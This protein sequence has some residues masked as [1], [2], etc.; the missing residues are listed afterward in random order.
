MTPPHLLVA[1][2]DLHTASV[3]GI[4]PPKV[5]LDNG[6]YY[7]ANQFQ[8]Y[9]W[10]IWRDM[11]KAIK[12]K[13]RVLGVPVTTIIMGDS[14]D[15]NKYSKN[16]VFAHNPNSMLRA[17]DELLKPVLK[18]SERVYVLRGTPAHEGE[19][20]WLAE[21]LA[22]RIKAV[23]RGKHNYSWW[24]LPIEVSGVL[25]DIK[26]HPESGDMRWWTAGGGMIRSAA[27]V[28]FD[29]IE[30]KDM[31]PQV[32]LR[33]HRHQWRDSGTNMPT[34]AFT[35]PAWQ[36][37]TD[38]IHRIGAGGSKVPKFGCAWFYCDSG[39]YEWGRF[40]YQPDRPEAEVI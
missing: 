10:D 15:K 30:T 13:T 19:E 26:H 17:A 28:I 16:G 38:F 39:D 27:T 3:T 24:H 18:L 12:K 2:G 31:P 32:V 36:G 34:R 1:I 25:F 4:C 22:E 40:M 20:A 33:G 21:A 11:W 5:Q 14:L 9:L 29:Y 8:L 23:P 35:I 7:Y 6:G 37:P